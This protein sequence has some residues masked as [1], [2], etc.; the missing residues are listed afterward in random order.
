LEGAAIPSCNDSLAMRSNLLYDAEQ[1]AMAKMPDV[2]NFIKG[3]SRRIE[4]AFTDY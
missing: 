3:T 1:L 2:Q 4:T